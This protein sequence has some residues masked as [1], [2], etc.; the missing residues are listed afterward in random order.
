MNK[1]LIVLTCFRGSKG[2]NHKIILVSAKDKS[3][4]IALVYRLKGSVNI[5]D[6]KIVDY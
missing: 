1:Y 2:F 6:I 3:D 4:A 5:V